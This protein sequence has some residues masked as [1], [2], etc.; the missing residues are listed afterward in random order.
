MEGH[1][2]KD[3]EELM[4]QNDIGVCLRL[5]KVCQQLKTHKMMYFCVLQPQQV[6]VHPKNR[7]GIMLGMHD[8][9]HK[10]QRLLQ[11]GTRVQLLEAHSYAIEMAA[12]MSQRQK[13]VQSNIDLA[14]TSDGLLPVP[15]GEERY[16]SLGA[17]HSCAF[18]RCL[19]Q[20]CVNPEGEKLTLEMDETLQYLAHH[21]W[22]WQVFTAECER[23]FPGLPSF[24]SNALNSSNN[25]AI[26]GTEIETAF[27]IAQMY[28]SGAKMEDA[29]SFT[30]SGEPRCKEY[31]D[32]VAF[33]LSKFCG[34]DSFPLIFWLHGFSILDWQ[35]TFV[36]IM[37]ANEP[38]LT[39]IALWMFLCGMC[40]LDEARNL[41]IHC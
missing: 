8:V 26:G 1:V 34:G 36:K 15:T 14:Q 10:G 31:I 17:S 35:L 20:G 4:G 11:S 28:M 18:T 29:L 9:H 30:K 33:L 6:L 25:N 19:M 37:F 3:L 32:D 41:G 13:Q 39:T 27:Q 21:G 23:L 2:T 22:Q 12:D 16:L 7:G 38:H 40:T 5:E 24:V